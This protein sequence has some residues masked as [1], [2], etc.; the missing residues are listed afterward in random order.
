[1]KRDAACDDQELASARSHAILSCLCAETHVESQSPLLRVV[2]KRTSKTYI[3]D[4]F[5]IHQDNRNLWRV[6]V[7]ECKELLLEYF[8]PVIGL[9]KWVMRSW[10]K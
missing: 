5:M 2:G 4:N 7:N 9:A 3:T 10:R 8:M 1:M 6:F